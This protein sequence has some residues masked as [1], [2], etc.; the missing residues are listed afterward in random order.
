MAATRQLV[1]A[2][3]SETRGFSKGFNDAQKSVGGFG[4]SLDQ[5]G[6][7]MQGFSSRTS[8][9]S[10]SLAKLAGAVSAALIIRQLTRYVRESVQAFAEFDDKLTQSTA[11]MG[12]LSDAVRDD[13]SQAARTIGRETRFAADQAAEAFF[14]L[15]SAGLDVEQSIAALPQVAQF[16]QAGMFDLA[17]AT[18]LL[19]DAQSALGLTVKDANKNL[20]NLTRVSDVLVKANTLS[21][22]TVQ[23]FSEAL[24]NRAAAAARL[25]GV[26]VEEVVSVLAAF[27]D[28]GLKGAAAGEA[29]SI[30][31]R[32]LQKAAFANKAEFQRL[33]VTVFDTAGNI[34]PLADIVEDLEGAFSGLSDEQKRATITALGF[35]E[36]SVNNLLTLIGTSDAIRRYGREL[37]TAGGITQEVADKQLESLAGQFDLVKSAFNDAKLE[38]G[39]QLA[40]ALRDI[41]PLLIGLADN[42]AILSESF[43]DTLVKGVEAAV[44]VVEGA[45]ETFLRL[46]AI[47]NGLVTGNQDA[48]R[49]FESAARVLE[50]LGDFRRGN[51]V[52]ANP[53]TQ[54]A[55]A[56]VD[57]ERQ[58]LLT[59]DSF[60]QLARG[61]GTTERETLQAARATR[62][63][64]LANKEGIPV[65][66][67]NAWIRTLELGLEESSELARLQSRFPEVFGASADAVGEFADTL[68]DV[69]AQQASDELAK[70][71]DAVAKT[72]DI[73]SD[74]AE[75]VEVSIQELLDNVSA[76]VEQNQR[77]ESA[78]RILASSGLDALAE[79]LRQKGPAAVGVAEELAADIPEAFRLDAEI[80]AAIDST[81]AVATLALQ[82]QQSSLARIF[83]QFGISLARAIE[84]GFSNLQ[85]T[86]TVAQAVGQ[87]VNQGNIVGGVRRSSGGIEARAIGGP[88][89]AGQQ[90]IVGERGPEMFV[91]RTNGTIVPNSQLS[92]RRPD[93]ERHRHLAR[94]RPRP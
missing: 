52:G 32:D 86:G 85:L 44:F 89:S 87:A 38:L 1:V 21:N 40:P 24:T 65:D 3:T 72:I 19:T 37:Q 11:I 79:Q 28:Q 70:L 74:A 26:E 7:S 93:R 81:L 6:R 33:G 77:F 62:D 49:G 80:R 73:F 16:A 43:G 13:L 59:E 14:F 10:A 84:L 34:V 66:E 91:P 64:I 48:A 76:Q 9:M 18:D 68:D 30:V 78:L 60:R 58:A 29:F 42:V 23:Q 94:T 36:R 82:G 45:Q 55:N 50:I 63:W 57:L 12:D 67:L 90:Y 47:W 83:E 61:I 22:A 88:V 71:R 15:A 17:L 51:L 35:Q 8:V 69:D 56:L 41:V 31:L 5:G 25:V 54:L 20:T 2:I 27:A 75:E 39:E 4:R 53:A 46:G 92:S